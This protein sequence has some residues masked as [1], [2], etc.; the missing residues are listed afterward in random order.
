MINNMNRLSFITVFT[1][2]K[3]AKIRYNSGNESR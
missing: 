1:V 3:D 2:A